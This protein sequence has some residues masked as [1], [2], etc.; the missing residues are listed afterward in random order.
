MKILILELARLGDIYQTWPALRALR[1]TY[2]KAEIHVLTRP[3]FSA[4]LEGLTAVDRIHQL[5][6][7]HLLE[8]LVQVNMD[9]K[10]S[11]DRISSYVDMLKANNFDWIVNFSFSPASSYL[12][13]ALSGPNTKVC[14]YSR[15]VDGFL[16]IPD[17]ISAYF[18]AQAGVGRPNRFHLI[19]LFGSMIQADI[20]PEDM[21]A[22]QL[23][24]FT[25]SL[26]KEFIALHVG[27]S[28]ANKALS[29]E[30]WAE[31][32]QSLISLHPIP[33][34]LIGAPGE[35]SISDRLQS[36]VPQA[37]FV[38]Y[39]GETSIPE[40]F[41][42]L[43]KAKV[44]LGCDSAPMHIATL[45]QTPCLNIS[46]ST[47]NFWETGPRSPGSYV[48]RFTQAADV[49]ADTV[50]IALK[51]MLTGEKQDLGLIP[52]QAGTPSYWALSPPSVDFDW[53]FVKAIYQG[54]HFPATTDKVFIQG[55]RKLS[56]VNLLMLEN[57][58]VI[59]AGTD[60]K[61]I[62][63]VLEQAE[64]II[65][66]IGKLSPSLQVVIRWYQTEKIRI[67]PQDF[68]GILT[69]TIEIHE[70]FQKLINIYLTSDQFKEQELK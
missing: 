69:R 12:T 70:L 21:R 55:L 33:I 32:V 4:A 23:P 56:D 66:A 13:H 46:L 68:K 5:P 20:L 29:A 26:P 18:Y 40:I 43:M 53:Q 47:V 45:T 67:G 35:K 6:T 60:P 16:S 42:I 31:I 22:P 8:P 7:T 64:E 44:L 17:D 1:R 34:V 9:V 36:L 65:E 58:A 2:P 14:G 19:E 52:V 62:T 57:L 50:G 24:D 28:Q 10:T 3:R 48:V 39:V 27:A 41:Q 25:G 51:R 61:N 59:Q 30:T 49:K 37:Q 54:E 63:P 11:Y 15:T 38:D